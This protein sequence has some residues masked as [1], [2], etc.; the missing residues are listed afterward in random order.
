MQ[1][2]H[3]EKDSLLTS[4]LYN[5]LSWI[6][7]RNCSTLLTASN[8]NIERLPTSNAETQEKIHSVQRYTMK[9]GLDVRYIFLDKEGKREKHL[10][11]FVLQCSSGV[12][13]SANEDE[14]YY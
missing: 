3:W 7:A 5:Q 12:D 1:Q 2:L 10:D 14:D 13:N 11:T 8:M 4:L 6:S 9:E